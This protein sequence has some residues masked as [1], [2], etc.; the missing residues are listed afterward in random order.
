MWYEERIEDKFLKTLAFCSMAICWRLLFPLCCFL[1]VCVCVCV[2][3]HASS[4]VPNPLL[5][6]M[7]VCTCM[8]S[9]VRLFAPFCVCVYMCVFSCVW[10]CYFMDWNPLGSSVQG[11]FQA[12]I[13]SRWPFSPAADLPEPGIE[14]LSSALAGGFFTSEPPGKPFR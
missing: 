4:V 11:I 5:L 14:P 7:C 6:R 8:L 3:V 2:C 9:C 10:L 13:M 1:I 12:R